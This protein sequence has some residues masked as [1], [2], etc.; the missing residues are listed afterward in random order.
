MSLVIE[1]REHP[2]YTGQSKPEHD[3]VA[4]R[5]LRSFVLE[6]PPADVGSWVQTALALGE[7]AVAELPPQPQPSERVDDAADGEEG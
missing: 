2:D 7:L 3:C 4:C 1:C 6:S 5:C